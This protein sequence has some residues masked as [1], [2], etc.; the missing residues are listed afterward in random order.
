ML[1]ALDFLGSMHVPSENPIHISS[2]L[3]VA[4]LLYPDMFQDVGDVGCHASVSKLKRSLLVIMEKV[5]GTASTGQLRCRQCS[6]ASSS[7]VF[8]PVMEI[9]KI[10]TSLSR[11]LL[12][13]IE[14]TTRRRFWCETCQGYRDFYADKLRS[15]LPYVFLV[16]P[17]VWRSFTKIEEELMVRRDDLT[18]FLKVARVCSG[19]DNLDCRASSPKAMARMNSISSQG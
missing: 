11:S 1:A 13:A 7:A 2:F 14:M 15:R 4:G 6:S 9:P 12:L 10:H 8:S 18:L 5:L 16:D 17:S 19:R 3:R